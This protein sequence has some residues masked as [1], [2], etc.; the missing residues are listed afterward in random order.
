MS[1][2]RWPWDEVYL[3]AD[4]DEHERQLQAIRRRPR[5]HRSCRPPPEPI[6]CATCGNDSRG[7]HVF[8]GPDRLCFD[9]GVKA[10]Q[11]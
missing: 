1:A 6:P 7:L 9:C 3:T 10:M 2:V 4:V 8:V 11:P 5:K